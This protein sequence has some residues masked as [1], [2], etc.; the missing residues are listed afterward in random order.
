MGQGDFDL[1][2]GGEV[3]HVAL[4]GLPE[5]DDVDEVVGGKLLAGAHIVLRGSLS[6]LEA[7]DIGLHLQPILKLGVLTIKLEGT[8]DL[9]DSLYT[10][11]VGSDV[12]EEANI[13]LKAFSDRRG[14]LAIGL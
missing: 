11:G 13:K 1:E 9:L 3:P 7:R 10:G 6:G 12:L 8:L 4:G 5:S 14:H 2:A